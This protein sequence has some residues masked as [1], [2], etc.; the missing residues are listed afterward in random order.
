MWRGSKLH[1]SKFQGRSFVPQADFQF[2]LVVGV[3]VGVRAAIFTSIR[4]AS[5]SLPLTDYVKRGWPRL[6]PV[7]SIHSPSHGTAW[8]HAPTTNPTNRP[9][10]S[11]SIH[12]CLDFYN[13]LDQELSSVYIVAVYAI[14]RRIVSFP[15]GRADDLSRWS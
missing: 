10:R 1:G 3:T 15:Q 8:V 2:Q 9:S 11:C 5:A 4:F 7:A 12:L 6:P 13:T 14:V